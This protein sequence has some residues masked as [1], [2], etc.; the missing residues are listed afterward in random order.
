MDGAH[1]TFV[2]S[3]TGVPLSPHFHGRTGPMRTMRAMRTIFL[4]PFTSLSYE[5]LVPV[6]FSRFFYKR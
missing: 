4:Q 5:H 6:S 1:G 3:R 2:G